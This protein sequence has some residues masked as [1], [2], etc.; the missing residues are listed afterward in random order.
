ML[1]VRGP[2]LGDQFALEPLVESPPMPGGNP[3]R[4]L[5][6][7]KADL[8]LGVYP[9]PMR[10]TRALQTIYPKT[11]SSK[12][13]LLLTRKILQTTLHILKCELQYLPSTTQASR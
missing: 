9:Y 7:W 6:G 11:P 5:L 1:P 12:T 13:N 4:R 3:W 8:D 10:M 2:C